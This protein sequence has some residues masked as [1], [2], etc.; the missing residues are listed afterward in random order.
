MRLSVGLLDMTTNKASLAGVCRIDNCDRN[1]CHLCLVCEKAPELGERPVAALGSVLFALNPRP[2]SDAGQVF[3]GYPALRACGIRNESPAD[4]VVDITLKQLLFTAKPIQLAACGLCPLG[5]KLNSQPVVLQAVA[6]DHCAGH[7]LAITR[8]SDIRFAKVNAK[9]L[10]HLLFVW[11]GN[12]TDGE[13]VEQIALLAVDQIAFALA[14]LKQ[15]ALLVSRQIGHSLS[16]IDCPDTDLLVAKLPGKNSVVIGY[17]PM[18]LERPLDISIQVVGVG[19]LGNAADHK[20]RSQARF[21]SYRAIDEALNVVATKRLSL[22]CLLAYVVAQSIAVLKRLEKRGVL[23]RCRLQL[24]LGDEFHNM[25]IIALTFERVKPQVFWW[26]RAQFLPQLKQ[27][28]SLRHQIV[29]SPRSTGSFVQN[30]HRGIDVA[31]VQEATV[32][33]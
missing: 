18:R 6:L 17:C 15:L 2:R 30:V 13:H 4:L 23:L 14:L 28:A 10:I 27:W 1:S 24:D 22:P 11:V 19:N 31:V 25:T 21:F 16:A 12:I 32:E 20:L 33:A 8:G 9:K 3:D 7:D 29:T 5:L 26:R